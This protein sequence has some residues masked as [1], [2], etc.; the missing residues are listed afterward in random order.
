VPFS[1][2]HAVQAPVAVGD[3]RAAALVEQV[4]DA[5]EVGPLLGDPLRAEDPAGLLVG[6]ADHLQRPAE[7]S[8]GARE[9]RR[10]DGL[11][12]GLVLH[13]D[14]AA[15]V[16]E[17]VAQLGAPRV[18]GPVLGVGEHG[19]DVREVAERRTVAASIG[20]DQVRA[21]RLG[22]VELD[23]EP[24]VG[25]VVREPLLAFALVA[26]RIDRAEADQRGEDLRRLLLQVHR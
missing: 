16:Q 14:R 20:R 5:R 13:V 8:A 4:V 2:T 25:Q 19:V 22:A 17:P 9:V 3:H 1:A 10:R 7:A 6:D 26:R 15:A 24:R 23:V 11:G 18:G 12:R 21:L